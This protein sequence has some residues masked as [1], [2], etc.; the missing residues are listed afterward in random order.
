MDRGLGF[1]VL[2][3]PARL[4]CVTPLQVFLFNCV[5]STMYVHIDRFT[6]LITYHWASY[7]ISSQVV[8]VVVVGPVQL[9]LF[10]RFQ[11]G[12]YFLLVC[13]ALLWPCVFADYHLAS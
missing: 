10:R 8:N 6:F 11:V 3:A 7:W 13:C 4:V 9:F 1:G 2:C 12:V 5:W